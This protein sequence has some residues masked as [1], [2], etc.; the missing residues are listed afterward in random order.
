MVDLLVRRAPVFLIVGAVAFTAFWSSG[1]VGMDLPWALTLPLHA[2]AMLLLGA[3]VIGMQMRQVRSR[4]DA[5]WSWAPVALVVAALPVSF[6]LF[7]VGVLLF[8]GTAV[9]LKRLSAVGALTL[10]VGAVAFL[11]G[12]VGHGPFWSES[13]PQPEGMLAVMFLTG[14]VLMGAGWIV[15]AIR[16]RQDVV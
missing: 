8:A 16:E 2:V 13:N 7:T 9:A 5:P 1:V 15:L 6:E 4:P 14:L 11:V 3:G 10:A 12:R